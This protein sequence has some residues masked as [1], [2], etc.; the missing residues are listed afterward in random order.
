MTECKCITQKITV[1]RWMKKVTWHEKIWGLNGFLGSYVFTI[2]GDTIE[3]IEQKKNEVKAFYEK[4][5]S[6]EEITVRSES[7]Y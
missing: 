7:G 4:K 5:Y 3:E 6:D 1:K 2:H